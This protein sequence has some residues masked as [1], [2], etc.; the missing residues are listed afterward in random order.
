L[1]TGPFAC[2]REDTC[3]GKPPHAWGYR[4]FATKED[5]EKHGQEQAERLARDREL[6][7]L[8][9]EVGET[10]LP[11]YLHRVSEDLRTAGNRE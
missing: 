11:A 7:K 2:R 6:A 8:R 10:G 9:Q 5:I 4:E 1:P 3:S